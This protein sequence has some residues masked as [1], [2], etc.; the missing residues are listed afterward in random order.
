MV[1]V[2]PAEVSDTSACY[3]CAV[4]CLSGGDVIYANDIVHI[5]A[6]CIICESLPV[7]RQLIFDRVDSIVIIFLWN[8]V[9]F[10]K[11]A[12]F[13]VEASDRLIGHSQKNTVVIGKDRLLLNKLIRT[14]SIGPF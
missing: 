2:A 4:A 10:N 13:I 7:R 1:I 12:G 8:T 14:C 5:I 9:F 6:I 3:Y 11:S